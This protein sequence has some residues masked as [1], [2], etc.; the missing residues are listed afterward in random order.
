MNANLIK[1]I[2]QFWFGDVT[3]EHPMP[4]EQVISQWW[5]KDATLDQKIRLQYEPHLKAVE[6]GK[7]T[8]WMT[9]SKGCLAFILLTDQ[10]SRH[11]YRDSAQAFMYDP[12]ALAAA[13]ICVDSGMDQQLLPVQR[14]FVYMPFEHSES[15]ENQHRS[16][17]LFQLLLDS[18]EER[19]KK[20]F[21]GFLNYAKDHLKV[22]EQFDRFPHR[23][24][25]VERESSEAE[26]AYLAEPGA[27][28]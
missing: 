14:A 11:I 6:K 23:N 2:A 28:F 20:L 13:E 5:K 9:T 19:Q 1:E 12:I 10:F 15:I 7:L 18:V 17:E 4:N 27:G 16:I 24:R 3:E 22:I 8:E 26:L 21:E 25:V